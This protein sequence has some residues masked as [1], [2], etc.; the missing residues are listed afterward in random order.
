MTV[1]AGT[2]SKSSIFSIKTIWEEE[3][4]EV[5]NYLNLFDIHITKVLQIATIALPKCKVVFLIKDK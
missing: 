5:V 3:F 1:Q 4:L 2:Y